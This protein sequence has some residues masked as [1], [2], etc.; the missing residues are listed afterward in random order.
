MKGKYIGREDVIEKFGVPPEK[1]TDVQAL[2]GDATDNIPGVPGI[3]IKTAAQLIGEYGDLETLLARAGE[4]KQPKRRESLTVHAENARISK[5]LAT[6]DA[7]AAVPLALESFEAHDPN[8]PRLAL[9]LKEQGFNSVLARLRGTS[10]AATGSRVIDKTAEKA[11]AA[12][13]KAQEAPQFLPHLPPPSENRYTLINDAQTLQQWID[14][15]YETGV[16]AVDT[17]TTSLTPAK[18]DLVGISLSPQIGIGAYIPLGHVQE[19]DLLGGGAP[20]IPQMEAAEALRLLKPVLEDARVLKIGHNVKYDYQM[21]AARGIEMAPCDDTLLLSF[22]LDG[23]AHG[24]GMDELAEIFCQHS[25]IKYKD[26]CGSGKNQITFDRADIEKARDYAAEDAEITL[27]L[28]H[29]LKP[30]IA[31]EQVAR[32]YEDVERPV[33]SVIAE[34]E[35]A[36]ILIDPAALKEMSRDF[37]ERIAALEREIYALAGTEFNVASP[38]QLGVILFEQMGLQG[39]RKTKGGDWSTAVD[40]LEDLAGDHEIVRKLLDWRQISKLKS[41]YTDALQ[42]QVNPRTGRVH[43]SFSMTGASTGRL[44]SSDPN[45]QN[46]PIRT[47]EGRKIREAFVAAPGHC[48]LSAD[49][50]QVELRL[51]AEMADVAALKKAFRDNVDIHA[52]TAAQVFGLRLE[53]VDAE[54]RRQAKAVNFGIIYGISGWGLAKQLGTSPNEAGEFIRR[55]LARFPEIQTYMEA[56]KEEARA[57]GFVRTLYGRKIVI[58]NITSKIQG[59]RGGAERQAIN[60]PLQGTAA[61]IMKMAMARIPAALAEA[62]LAAKML[63]Q[64]HD[65]LVFEV[66]DAEREA[67]AALV[68]NIM[69]NAAQLDVPLI[70]EAGFGASWAEAH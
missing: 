6:L 17:E 25:T 47:A 22:L 12:A 60:A 11:V 48:I 62:G 23:I 3:G 10:A 69:E 50:S 44:A 58:P 20:E 67:T 24:H 21:F 36:G 28:H 64:V 32:V 65:E 42:E 8:T 4:I 52:L 30:R 70:A 9:F 55:Y 66:P 7:N 29:I 33:I 37:A 31:A 5:K 53:D 59:L 39:G 45:L 54:L 27:R 1:V 13:T 38:K 57:H 43:T 2:A 15:A 61:D 34:M 19:R 41:T 46:I 14:H 26:I 16:L 35:R 63:L 56:R 51:A 40:V 49:Y 68:R 18:A